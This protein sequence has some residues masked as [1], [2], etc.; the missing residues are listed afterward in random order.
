MVISWHVIVNLIRSNSARDQ[1]ACQLSSEDTIL[2]VYGPA[3]DG[4][5]DGKLPIL[6]STHVLTSA[7][8]FKGLFPPSPS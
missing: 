7:P 6:L 1:V 3:T 5:G 2:P 4:V 8:T